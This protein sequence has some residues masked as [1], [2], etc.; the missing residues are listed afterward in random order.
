MLTHEFFT[1]AKMPTTFKPVQPMIKKPKMLTT[2][3]GTHASSNILVT[4]IVEQPFGLG[5]K[6]SNNL[7]GVLFRDLTSMVLKCTF[8]FQYRDKKLNEFSLHT[9]PSVLHKKVQ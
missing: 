2:S 1:C 4:Q 8:N 5:Y 7:I 9:Y 3:A 6:L